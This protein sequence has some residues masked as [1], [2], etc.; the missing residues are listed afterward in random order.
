MYIVFV[1]AFFAENE[2][3]PLAGM[4]GYIY[5]ISKY[6]QE[7]GHKVEIVAGSGYFK[8][9]KYKGIQVYNCAVPQELKGNYI[10]ISCEILRREIIFQKK[11][12]ELNDKEIIDIVQYAGWSGVG[13]LHSLKCP[14]ILR[15]STYSSVQYKE[16]AVF[17][18]NI[19]CF[20]FWEKMAGR[21]ADGILSPSIVLGKKFGKDIHKKV[22]I[23][24]TPYNDMVKE[25]SA[26]FHKELEGRE[27]I[28]F[29][30]QTSRDKGFH[31]IEK[32]MPYFLE[33]YNRFY[34]VVAGW[35][36]PEEDGDS[37]GKLR[38]KLGKTA[39]RF[40]YLGPVKQE[41]LFPIIRGARCVLIP[42]LIDNLPNSCLEALYLGQVVIGT[43][44][45]SLEQLIVNNKNGFLIK[46]GDD[47]ELLNIVEKVCNL[48]QMEREELISG[49]ISILRRYSPIYAVNKLEQYYRWVILRKGKCNGI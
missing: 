19:R 10:K 43:Y 15:I 37:I 25:D 6:L 22:T 20:S 38:K 30:G 45:T 18:K 26:L 7:K 1:T 16:S 23:M 14:G 35:N 31:V 2:Q 28:L 8:K 33:K 39:E 46:A 34:F 11:L 49:S 48:S 12:N 44:G 21:H 24:E 40:L 41:L 32:M 5:K 17:K 4:P 13:C 29:Y 27:Y 42:S 47:R 36:S 3:T 9:W